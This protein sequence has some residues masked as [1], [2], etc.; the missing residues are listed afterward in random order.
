MSIQREVLEGQTGSHRARSEPTSEGGPLPE[1]VKNLH[2]KW[3]NLRYFLA[4]KVLF[5]YRLI[6]ILNCRFNYYTCL[7]RANFNETNA[8]SMLGN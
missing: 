4:M 6:V 5:Q 7:C 1:N 3:C 8:K 2:G